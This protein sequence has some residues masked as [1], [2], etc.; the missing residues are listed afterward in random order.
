LFLS[1]LTPL[2]FRV[3]AAVC[4]NAWLPVLGDFDGLQP[5]PFRGPLRP[6]QPAGSNVLFF[7][8]LSRSFSYGSLR[9]AV[10]FLRRKNWVYFGKASPIGI[11]AFYSS[12]FF[13]FLIG[14]R[15]RPTFGFTPCFS[16]P[17]FFRVDG[18]FSPIIP[19]PRTSNG[20]PSGFFSFVP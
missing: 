2:P 5:L 10:N 17:R 9:P 20:N 3:P 18:F 13:L 4:S 7:T 16:P 11:D 6:L 1:F 15:E 19:P 14:S 8:L 12:P